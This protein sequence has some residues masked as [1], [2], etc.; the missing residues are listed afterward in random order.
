FAIAED[1]GLSQAEYDHVCRKLERIPNYAELGIFSA[2]YSEHCSYKSS[3]KFLK[4][5]PTSGKR[6][7]QGPGENAG[8]IDVGHGWAVAFKV[9]SHNHPS[10][11]EP[12]QGAA[13]GVGGILRDV[14]TMGARPI[15]AMD[16]LCF[17]SRDNEKTPHLVKGIVKGVGDYGNNFGVP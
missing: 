4:K 17:G 1:L 14:F 9:E 6:V 12:F 7:L 5:L 3:R 2:M 8:V 15:G 10:Y 16:G 13:T 11:I